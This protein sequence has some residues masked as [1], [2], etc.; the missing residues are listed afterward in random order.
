M[1]IGNNKVKSY[2]SK[3]FKQIPNSKEFY[4]TTLPISKILT[5]DLDVTNLP[6]QL[7]YDQSYKDDLQ[8]KLEHPTQGKNSPNKKIIKIKGKSTDDS[9]SGGD[10]LSNE[11]MYRTTRKRD[12]LGFNK[13]KAVG[14]V[15]ISSIQ[16][17]K[18][19]INI[20]TKIVTNASK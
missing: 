16:I 5:G 6:T 15:H 4:E 9:G 19:F 17:P 1:N 18:E 20:L 3:R 14:H 13:T 8:N 12:E 7:F 2:N 10:Y 11:I